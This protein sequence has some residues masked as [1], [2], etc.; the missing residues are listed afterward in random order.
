MLFIKMIKQKTP[1]NVFK[2]VLYIN[3]ISSKILLVKN[4]YLIKKQD[5][6]PLSRTRSC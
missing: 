1:E 4:V 5:I 3:I 2:N 6:C